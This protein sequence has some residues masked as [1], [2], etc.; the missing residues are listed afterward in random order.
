[1][2]DAVVADAT[3]LLAAQRQEEEEEAA[4][5]PEV[6]LALVA[7]GDPVAPTEEAAGVVQAPVGQGELAVGLPSASEKS[8]PTASSGDRED[9]EAAVSEGSLL[10]QMT[11]LRAILQGDPSAP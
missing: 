2:R 11:Q 10:A 6:V 3:A 4:K 5:G 8:G 1:M 9:P 7:S